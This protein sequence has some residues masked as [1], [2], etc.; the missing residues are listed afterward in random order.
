MRP[1]VG[2]CTLNMANSFFQQ[3]CGYRKMKLQVLRF[4]N[5][6]IHRIIPRIIHRITHDPNMLAG[7][8][9]QCSAMVA[10]PSCSY[11]ARVGKLD[12]RSMLLGDS[13]DTA[14][15]IRPNGSHELIPAVG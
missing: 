6:I 1:A 3:A 9:V 13:P 8:L 5:V 15:T 11:P 14:I 7:A 2:A 10:C 12:E 4:N